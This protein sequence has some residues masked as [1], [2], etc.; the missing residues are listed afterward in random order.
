M[1]CQL[2][3]LTAE[4]RMYTSNLSR[5]G[6]YDTHSFVHFKWRDFVKWTVRDV[7]VQ[8]KWIYWHCVECC[9]RMA[10]VCSVARSVTDLY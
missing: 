6:T 9:H 1:A 7:V 5:H 8:V 10:M 4:Y 2:R 3:A